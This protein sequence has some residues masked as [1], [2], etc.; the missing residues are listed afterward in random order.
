[1]IE[2]VMFWNEP[3]NKSH[4]DFEAL[5]PE[6]HIYSS[7]VD[8]VAQAVAVERQAVNIPE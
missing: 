2:A 4:R 6:R 8:P 1:M 5:H 7:M 3:N